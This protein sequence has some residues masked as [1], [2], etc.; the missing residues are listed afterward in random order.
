LLVHGFP[1]LQ[2]AVLWT[3]RHPKPG[4]QLSSVQGLPSLQFNVVP[5]TQELATQVSMPLHTLPSSQSTS[6]TQQPGT[7]VP[8]VH[9]PDWH[10]SSPLQSKPSVQDVPSGSW[11]VA[12]APAP[13]QE[14]GFV[15]FV[16]A[17]EP[18]G[19]PAMA[20]VCWQPSGSIHESDVQALPSLQLGGVPGTTEPPE[21]VSMPLQNN[22]SLGSFELSGVNTH[23]PE[24]QSSSVQGL[25]SLHSPGP[26][27]LTHPGIADPAHAP[28]E[29]TSF[30]VHEFASSQVSE[31][32]V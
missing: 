20:G 32:S 22:P 24:M 29:Q 30:S 14:S 19:V 1:S 23:A 18:Q 27:Q 10:D 9:R 5:E 6:A 26:E 17:D 2:G 4:T 3:F 31:L 12:Q 21:Q 25:E 16:L 15:Q 7:G 13:L 28:A 11:L 8:G